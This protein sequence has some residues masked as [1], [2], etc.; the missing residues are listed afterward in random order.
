[1]SKTLAGAVLS[2]L[3]TPAIMVLTINE[4]DPETVYV[5]RA[6]NPRILAT[7][8]RAYD[9]LFGETYLEII[10]PTGYGFR[11][12]ASSVSE[13]VTAMESV[14]GYPTGADKR[15]NYSKPK[16]KEQFADWDNK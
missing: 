3:N 8:V 4:T 12:V 16:Y 9:E 14:K 11:K 6:S 5:Y 15:R 10:P 1:M 2:A 7:V 13:F